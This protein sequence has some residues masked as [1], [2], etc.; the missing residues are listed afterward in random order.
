MTEK[1]KRPRKTGLREEIEERRHRRE[2]RQSG[3]RCNHSTQ[4]V[5]DTI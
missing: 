3:S 5:D 4:D 1:K 2:K